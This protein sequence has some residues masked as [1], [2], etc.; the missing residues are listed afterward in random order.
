[1]SKKTELFLK[2]DIQQEG[3][4]CPAWLSRPT[5]PSHEIRRPISQ[6]P[7]IEL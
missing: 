3:A 1:M 2:V 7:G 5:R 6:E 4:R